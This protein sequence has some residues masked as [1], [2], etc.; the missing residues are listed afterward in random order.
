MLSMNDAKAGHLIEVPRRNWRL[1]L[2]GLLDIISSGLLLFALTP[3][4]IFIAIAIKLTS[5]GPVFF[6]QTRCGLNGREFTFY[7]FRTM[8]EHAERLLP[9]LLAHNEMNGPVFKMHNDPRV[10]RLGK[11]LR[12][13][14]LDELPQ[15]WNVLKRDMSL[16]GPRPHLA[17][18]VELYSAWQ[19]GRLSMR[20]GITCHWQVSGRN[21]ITDFDEWVRLDLHY[22]ENWTLQGDF[23]LLIKTIPT[24]ISGIGAK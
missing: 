23:E 1:Y 12:R 13:A 17:E 24:V 6:K 16:V 10:T 11:Y 8:S 9:E 3:L 14:S 15:L 22:I 19:R 21:H 4:F 7:K 2:K 5:K 20:P 18:E